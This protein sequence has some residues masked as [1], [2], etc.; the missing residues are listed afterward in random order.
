MS[1]DRTFK[2]GKAVT[3]TA[4]EEV[5]EQV[6][7]LVSQMLGGQK[8]RPR[9]PDSHD[10]LWA[11]G[12]VTVAVEQLRE[13]GYDAVTMRSIAGELGPGPASLYAHVANRAELDQLVVG[14]VCGQ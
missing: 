3:V 13:R 4:P 14:W 5:A 7:A 11:D 1:G 8:G 10:R 6:S 2:L 12:I 9:K